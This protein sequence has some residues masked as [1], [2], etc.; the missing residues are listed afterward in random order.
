[1][2]CCWQ[3]VSARC[4]VCSE[5]VGTYRARYGIRAQ[6]RAEEWLRRKKVA[7]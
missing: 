5:F 7:K 1:M 2:S 3:E 6:S 4:K